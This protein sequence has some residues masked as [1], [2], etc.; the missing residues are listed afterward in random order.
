MCGTGRIRTNIMAEIVTLLLNI[1]TEIFRHLTESQSR[2]SE[3]LS[4]EPEASWLKAIQ[5]NLENQNL[6][7]NIVKELLN[8]ILRKKAFQMN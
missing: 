8:G 2:I 5:K 4:L 7:N 1:L 3:E 6:Y